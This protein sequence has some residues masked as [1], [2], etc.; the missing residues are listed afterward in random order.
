MTSQLLEWEEQGVGG[1]GREGV[2]E[3]EERDVEE[4]GLTLSITEGGKEGKSKVITSCRHLEEKFQE[5]SKKG[6]VAMATSVETPGVDLTTRTKQL[7][8]KEKSRSTKREARL[9]L[10]RKKIFQKSC[11]RTG[12]RKLP[13]T[14]LV[15]ARAWRGQAAGMT[16]TE[17]LMLRRQMAAA[18]GKK[19]SASLS[20]FT[21]VNCL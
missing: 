2:K 1:F 20:L 14:D 16:P 17:R 18:A 10:I 12:V 4:K 13:R 9:P 21:E 15:P 7:G 11:M 8:A 6:G 19:E 3:V 5:C